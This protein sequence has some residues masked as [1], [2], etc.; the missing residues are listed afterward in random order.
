LPDE[1]F[2]IVAGDL[3]HASPSDEWRSSRRTF[4]AAHVF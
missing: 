4:S 1:P 3:H 2:L